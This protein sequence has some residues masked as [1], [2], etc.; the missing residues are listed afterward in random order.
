M[1]LC[2]RFLSNLERFKETVGRNNAEE[3]ILNLSDTDQRKLNCYPGTVKV[4]AA[5]NY[6]L[7]SFISLKKK[8]M[9]KV[10]NKK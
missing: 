1:M 2:L 9:N 10:K 7:C 3:V 8:K 6:H 5:S 4:R